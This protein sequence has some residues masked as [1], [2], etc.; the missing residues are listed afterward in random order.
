MLNC[1]L[2][3]RL[4]AAKFKNLFHDSSVYVLCMASWWPAGMLVH[5]VTSH[6]MENRSFFVVVHVKFE[7][8]AYVCNLERLS[9]LL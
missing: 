4:P 9:R 7:F 1:V 3:L 5:Y 8:I 2:L 6:F